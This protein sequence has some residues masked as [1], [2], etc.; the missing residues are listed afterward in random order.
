MINTNRLIR[1]YY[2][3]LQVFQKPSK[4]HSH[5][6]VRVCL[7]TRL[8]RR[9]DTWSLTTRSLTW[10]DFEPNSPATTSSSASRSVAA[11]T[12]CKSCCCS[13][14]V[15]N[16]NSSSSMP[17]SFVITCRAKASRRHALS[18]LPWP[19]PPLL[20]PLA[21]SL[22]SPRPWSARRSRSLP[23]GLLGSPETTFRSHLQYKA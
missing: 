9:T 14:F 19:P 22:P 11:R 13:S 3:P 6:T 2:S 8:C 21:Q 20:G 10:L 16:A 5:M 4:A 7:H 18:P 1:H 17:A 12:F 23:V 15:E